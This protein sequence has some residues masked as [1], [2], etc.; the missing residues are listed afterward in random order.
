M[1]I[2]NTKLKQT[3]TSILELYKHKFK[4]A[5]AIASFIISNLKSQ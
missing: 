3:E 5:K 4:Y 1:M 2:I